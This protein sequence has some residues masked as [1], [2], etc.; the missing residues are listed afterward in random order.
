[1][2]A[3]TLARIQSELQGRTKLVAVT[4]TRSADEIMQVYQA[5]QRIMGENRVQELVT[6]QAQL[7][8]DI[9]WHLLSATCKP[10][11]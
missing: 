1:M 9:E 11:R 4:K 10:I 5:G 3:S 8:A 6:K 7:P 2:I